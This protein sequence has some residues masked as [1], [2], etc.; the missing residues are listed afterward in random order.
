[1]GKYNKSKFTL[2]LINPNFSPIFCKPYPIAQ[3]HM[4]VFHLELQ[5]L[6]NKGVLEHAPSEWAFPTFI[7]P[8]KDGRVR[9]VSD[10]RK[11]NKL[12]KRP[13][14]FLPSISEIMQRRK[15]FKFITKIDIAMG[16][17]TFEID[18]PS[19]Q[20]CIIS[21]PYGLYKYKRL[22]MGI[23]NSPDLFQ[24]VMHP[25]FS[26]LPNVECFLDDIGIFSLGSFADQ[27]SQ[28]H[29]VLLRLE[30][31]GF[32]VNPLKCDWAVTTTEYLGF[33]LTSDG[34]KPLPHKIKA[35]TNISRPTSTKYI[36]PFVGLVNY[37]KD[38]WPKRAHYLTPLTDVCSTRK[39]FVWN[40]AQEHAFHNIKRLV[41]EDVMLHFPDHSKPFEIDTNASKYQI[42][43][44]IKQEQLPIAYFS[45]KLTP[46]QRR[47][48]TIE[49]EMLA[50]IEVLKEYRNFLLGAEIIIFT[51]HKNL[52][53]N[54]ST[55][56]RVF[57]WK[58][59]IEEFG[60]TIQYVQG[61]TN[62]EADALSRLP[63]LEDQREMEVMLNYPQ[64]DPNHPNL[65]SYPLDLK[66]IH[67]YQQLD[68]AI[69]KAV[70]EDPR[71][72]FLTIYGNQSV[73]H[74]LKN[75]NRQLL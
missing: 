24:S 68:P 59:K 61:H 6:I 5:H 73:I 27:I 13:R 74:Q 65:S 11:L 48:S 70:E 56:D 40:D 15:G 42:G 64:V 17:S 30:R 25:L 18:A 47:Y 69:L 53:A 23:T 28:I 37:Y 9:W 58:Q 54:S 60:P 45:R 41:S 63:L 8:I 21:T 3:T 7:I 43:A 31:N 75:S 71:F 20:L 67:K 72:K 51:D 66:L 14:Y 26:D 4:E 39:K 32:T 36:R 50:I 49:Q 44:K 19:Q 57:R 33:L 55:D 35:I 29:Q 62:T 2:E 46:T 16:F 38:M 22:P 10:F 52:L 1:M 12:L 34:I